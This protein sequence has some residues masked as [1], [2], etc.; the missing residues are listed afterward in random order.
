MKH[1]M[2]AFTLVFGTIFLSCD[3]TDESFLNDTNATDST[4][5]GIDSI[6]I[7]DTVSIPTDTVWIPGDSIYFPADSITAPGDTVVLRKSLKLNIK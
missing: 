2:I 4:D 1:Y 3:D 5:T 6:I 7:I